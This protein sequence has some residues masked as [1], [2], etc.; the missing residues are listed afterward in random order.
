MIHRQPIPPNIE[1]FSYQKMDYLL[2][3]NFLLENA[4]IDKKVEW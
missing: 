4:V 3:I 1:I 2:E